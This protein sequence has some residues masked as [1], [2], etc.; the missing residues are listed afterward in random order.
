MPKFILTVL[1]T[2]VCYIPLWIFLLFRLLLQP[3]GFWQKLVLFGMGFWILGGIQLILIIIWA[4]VL[5]AIW[6][7]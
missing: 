2:V 6:G 1:A 7:D 3:E 4:I 5:F